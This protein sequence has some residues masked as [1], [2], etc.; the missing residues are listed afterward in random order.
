MDKGK[1]IRK[2]FLKLIIDVLIHAPELFGYAMKAYAAYYSGNYPEL[3][4]QI[5][6]GFDT[7]TDIA[8]DI[9]NGV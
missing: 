9:N 7:I 4:K 5:D 1:E 2:A 6:N 8:Q 3:I